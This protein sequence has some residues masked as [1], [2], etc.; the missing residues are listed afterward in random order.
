M[1]LITLADHKQESISLRVADN[2]DLTVPHRPVCCRLVMKNHRDSC[3]VW[4]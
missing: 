2:R 1:W 3:P 4:L